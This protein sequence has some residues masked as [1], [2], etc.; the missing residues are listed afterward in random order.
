MPGADL[1]ETFFRLL[2]DYTKQ[3]SLVEQL[4]DEIESAYSGHNRHYHNLQHLDHLLKQLIEVKSKIKN[5]NTIL[6]SLYY[7]DIAYDVLKSDNEEASALL[8]EKR[9]MQ[10]GVPAEVIEKCKSQILA[11]KSHINNADE[12]TNYFTDADLS[13][14]GHKPEAYYEYFKNIRKEYSIYPDTIYNEGRQKVL[15]HFLA[16]ERIFKTDFFYTKFEKQAKE[17]LQAESA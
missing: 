16:M 11:T 6:F 1:K 8:S 15:Q 17:N 13:I 3:K 14:L 5:W 4:W 2:A 10:V 12:D 9:M 7:H